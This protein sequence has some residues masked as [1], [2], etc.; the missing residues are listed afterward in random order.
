MDV[1]YI[2]V[3]ILFTIESEEDIYVIANMPLVGEKGCCCRC[4][5][6]G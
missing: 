5:S 4:G 2:L 1:I 3:K 6:H